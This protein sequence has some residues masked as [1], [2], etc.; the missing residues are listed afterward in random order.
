MDQ[1]V[2]AGNDL[3]ECTELG[4][5][6][7]SSLD[8]IADLVLLNELCPGVLI[9]ILS[10]EGNSLLLRIEGLNDNGDLVAFLNDVL[11]VADSVPG[12]LAGSY[13]AVNWTDVNEYAVVLDG[14]NLALE[15]LTNLNALPE[16]SSLSVANLSGSLTD[17]TN[18]SVALLVDLDYLKYTGVTMDQFRANFTEVAKRQVDLRLAL[19][20]IAELEN[21]TVSDED[22]E[23]EYADMAEQYKMEADKI[24]AAVPAD[25]IKND[26][27]I[28]K[29]LDLVRDSAKIEEVTE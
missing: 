21:I 23:K 9:G 7:D 13:Q 19:E 6:Y 5:A 11:G 16:L 25:A 15:L 12:Q 3:C 14:A 17:R 2:N 10:G 29:A 28:E 24:K 4:N 8:N 18:N 20:K 27:K 1:T 22:V 26:L